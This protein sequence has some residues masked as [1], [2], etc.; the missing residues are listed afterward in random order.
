M[1]GFLCVSVTPR[2]EPGEQEQA[3]GADSQEQ[4]RQGEPLAERAG[5]VT[6]AGGVRSDRTAHRLAQREREREGLIG[7]DAVQPERDEGIAEDA[8]AEQECA[9]RDSRVRRRIALRV[10]VGAPCEQRDGHE[11]GRDCAV[12]ETMLEM[13][14]DKPE[15]DDDRDLPGAVL[16]ARKAARRHEKH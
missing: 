6:R 2:R 10:E 14:R 16:P 8:G 3:R 1:P 9:Q 13:E 15:K 5:K 12:A 11:S 4:D 7:H